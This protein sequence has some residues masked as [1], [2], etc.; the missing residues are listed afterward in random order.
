MFLSGFRSQPPRFSSEQTAG[1]TWLAWIHSQFSTTPQST[2]EKLFGRYGCGPE[3]IASR[4]FESP[5]YGRVSDEAKQRFAHYPIQER[6]AF[7]AEVAE[8]RMDEFYDGVVEA[9]AMLVHV[10][11]TGYVAPSAAQRMVVKRGW[12]RS[13]EILH[14]YHMGCYAALPAIRAAAAGMRGREGRADLVHNELC[15]LHLNPTLHTPEQFVVQSLFADGHIGYSMTAA[16]SS[17]SLE[18]LAI[19]EELIPDSEGAMTWDVGDFGFHMTLAREIPEL[20]QATVGGF[21]ERLAAAAGLQSQ[22]VDSA[23]YAIH[24]GGPRILDLAADTLRLR[25]P[26]LVQSRKVLRERGNMSSATLPHV[27]KEML[28]DESIEAGRKIMS[29]AFGPGLTV[30]GAVMQVH[31]ERP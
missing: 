23:V 17:P 26:Q 18:V 11:C 27:W 24:P 1:L 20:I 28:D 19:R 10:T 21:I 8:R 29:L 4:S 16:A 31:R 13:T 6:M 7:F 22:D 5:E 12:H 3:K 9:P 25:E 30:F 15:T 2:I 14:A